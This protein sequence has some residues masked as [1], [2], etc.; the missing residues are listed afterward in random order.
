MVDA[1]QIEQA[2]C[3]PILKL[4]PTGAKLKRHGR[5]YMTNCTFH[6]DSTPS[7]SL[8]KF[9]DGHWRYKCHGCGASG[10]PVTYLTKTKGL[11]F[12]EAVK[13]LSDT[14]KAAPV[15]PQPVAY[16]DYFGADGTLLYQSV[17]YEPKSFRLRRPG[18]SLSDP[19][20][21]WDLCGIERVL[22]RLPKLLAALEAND[23]R[24]GNDPAPFVS[25]TVY[26]VEGEKDVETLEKYGLLAT[27]HAGGALSFRAELLKPLVGRR[28]VVV[29]DRDDVGM[30]LMRKVFAAARTQGNPV[31]FLLLPSGKDCSDYFGQGGT[32]DG[33]LKEV[34]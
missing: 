31:G 29:P 22:Y 28:I 20:W 17:R 23:I 10:D 15:R 19:A 30:S 13:L 16:Y 34:R 8:F 18:S 9:D 33:F 27:T 25:S 2:R 24:S 12:M 21:I 3:Y 32:L 1:S 26:Y 6:D 5:G 4:L 14:A 7:L 11:D